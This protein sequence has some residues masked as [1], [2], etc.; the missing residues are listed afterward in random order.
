VRV[1]EHGDDCRCFLTIL[2][3][4]LTVSESVEGE[5]GAGWPHPHPRDLLEGAGGVCEKFHS[6][7]LLLQHLYEH[8]EKC[9]KIVG[10]HIEKNLNTKCPNYYCYFYWCHLSSKETQSVLSHA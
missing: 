9:V 5:E 1:R 3:N 4:V 10:S 6:S 7:E 8:H 2:D